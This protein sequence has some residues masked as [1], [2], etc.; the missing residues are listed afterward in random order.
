M[1]VSAHPFQCWCWLKFCTLAGEW[2]PMYY[3][4]HCWLLLAMP[5]QAIYALELTLGLVRRC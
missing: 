5:E 3:W 1:L 2:L 4:R